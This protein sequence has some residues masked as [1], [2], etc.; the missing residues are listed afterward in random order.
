MLNVMS[1]AIRHQRPKSSS[2]Y[3]LIKKGTDLITSK[4]VSSSKYKIVQNLSSG[5]SKPMKRKISFI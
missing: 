1:S 2:I 5:L 3:D 4:M